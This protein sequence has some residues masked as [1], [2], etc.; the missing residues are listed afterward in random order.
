[1]YLIIIT[2]KY[3]NWTEMLHLAAINSF[4]TDEYDGWNTRRDQRTPS[5]Q[6]IFL[7]YIIILSFSSL[8]DERSFPSSMIFVNF[9]RHFSLIT[10]VFRNINLSMF[11]PLFSLIAIRKDDQICSDLCIFSCRI[12]CLFSFCFLFIVLLVK[13]TNDPH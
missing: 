1:M 7:I 8:P 13:G 12:R 9:L 10:K 2:I 3:F 11:L 6:T 4:A 5:L